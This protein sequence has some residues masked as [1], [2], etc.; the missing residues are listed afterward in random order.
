MLKYTKLHNQANV[1]MYRWL[2]GNL[3]PWRV[4]SNCGSYGKTG[5]VEQV[6]N[7]DMDIFVHI[8]SSSSHYE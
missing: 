4:I 7:L 8:L 5:L 3:R 2:V 1:Y 6:K